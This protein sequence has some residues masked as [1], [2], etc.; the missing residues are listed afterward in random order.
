MVSNAAFSHGFFRGV[1]ATVSD[2]T[3]EIEGM[4]N[5]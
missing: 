1:R 4:D 3:T 2:A 5:Q